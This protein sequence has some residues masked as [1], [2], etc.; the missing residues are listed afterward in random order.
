MYAIRSY[1][2]PKAAAVT[3]LR[4]SSL[5]AAR[6]P[7]AAIAAALQA[8]RSIG[9]DTANRLQ[10]RYLKYDLNEDGQE[11]ALVQLGG[12]GPSGC[13]WLILEGQAGGY[14]PLGTMTGFQGPLL[15]APERQHGWHRNNFV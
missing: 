2:A 8:W 11:D 5:Q 12:C 7:D 15:V 14:R 9:S 10:Y 6:Q 4:S 3:D 13:D 1:Y